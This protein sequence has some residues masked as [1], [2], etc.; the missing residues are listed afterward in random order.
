MHE[1]MKKH[2]N[3]AVKKTLTIPTWLNTI[4]EKNDI[5]F[6]KLLQKAIKEELNI[7]Y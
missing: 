7:N 5:N 3:I 1:Y 4:A 6:S 2:S